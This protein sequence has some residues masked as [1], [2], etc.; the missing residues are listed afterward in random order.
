MV[1]SFSLLPPSAKDTGPHRHVEATTVMGSYS[2]FGGVLILI[3]G[4]RERGAPQRGV[5]KG[6]SGAILDE[7]IATR[8]ISTK[9]SA[10]ATPAQNGA[11][12]RSPG[13]VC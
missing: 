2:L 11:A 13:G 3:L 10:T 4:S 6:V 5:E 8:G 1:L 9:R 12:E 7:L